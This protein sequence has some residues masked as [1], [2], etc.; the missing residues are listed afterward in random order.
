M[1]SNY[2][3]S[4]RRGALTHAIIH[5][6][7]LQE[8]REISEN[9][10]SNGDNIYA[11]IILKRMRS[12]SYIFWLHTD[13]VIRF[14]SKGSDFNVSGVRPPRGACTWRYEM[15]EEGDMGW[16]KKKKKKVLS[17]LSDRDQKIDEG[18]REDGKKKE[19]MGGKKGHGER[20]GKSDAAKGMAEIVIHVKK[21]NL[22][23]LL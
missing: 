8:K 6:G 13:P 19:E 14:G 9:L 10:H 4:P 21:T 5:R 7:L 20:K 23:L 3:I 17:G 11:G 1:I 16:E 2:H 22:P 12:L 18:D 15:S